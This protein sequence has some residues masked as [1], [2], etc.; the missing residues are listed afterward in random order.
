MILI[1]PV[2]TVVLIVG[3]FCLGIYLQIKSEDYT[4]GSSVQGLLFPVLLRY[5]IDQEENRLSRSSQSSFM[6]ATFYPVSANHSA[7]TT[8]DFWDFHLGLTVLLEEHR[9]RM[10]QLSFDPSWR[11]QFLSFVSLDQV[12]GFEYSKLFSFM[13]QLRSRGG[14]AM[15]AYIIDDREESLAYT[16]YMRANQSAVMGTEFPKQD[17]Q[18]ILHMRK[19][20]FAERKSLVDQVMRREGITGFTRILFASSLTKAK[21]TL[22]QCIGLG[23]IQPNTSNFHESPTVNSSF[24]ELAGRL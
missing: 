13:S 3:V 4:W 15:L 12:F 19:L 22:I 6:P 17:V 7:E 9:M 24:N 8:D 20:L 23:D 21:R 14:L 18:I 16:E 5:L 1:S 11:P 2:S 10:A